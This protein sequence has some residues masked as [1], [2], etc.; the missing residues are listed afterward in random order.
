MKITVI[1][2]GSTYTPELVNG[3]LARVA[4]LPLTELCLMDIDEERLKIVGGFAQ[5]MVNAKGNPFKVTLT[6]DQREAVAGASYIITQLRVG[7][8]Q[9]RKGDEYLGQRHG[10]IG[11]ET[12]GVGGMAKA[13]RTIPV[14]QRIVDDMRELAPNA[15]LANFTNP[16]GLVTEMLTRYAPDIPAVGVC[17][18][19][20]TAKMTMLAEYEKMAGETVTEER[21]VLSTLGLNHLTWHSGFQVDGEE[22]WGEIFPA[23]LEELRQQ[24]APEWDIRT[25]ETLGIIPNYYLQYFYY[26]DKKLKAQA[27]WPPSRAEEVMAIEKDLLAQYADPALSAPPEDLMKRGGAYYSTLAT[28]LIASHHND[29]GQVHIVNLR[30]NG[31]VPEYPAD[32]VLEM[33]AK[34]DKSGIHPLPAKAL[35]LACF[36]IVNAVKMY[37]L[38]TVEAALHADRN[39]AYQALLAHPLGPSA[40][41]IQAVLDDML[42]TNRQWLP[43]FE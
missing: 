17:N 32:W 14:I 3:F 13:L 9:A 20:I 19:G 2:G 6:L 8:M 25:L 12:T 24:D 23:Y 33:P 4:S 27:A 41:K 7:M 29:L 35:P 37:E 40:D 38:L 10:L 15:L 30:N 39:A 1:G 34:V 43:Q 21:A 5:R 28:Q 22:K 16:A 18:V 26:T 42:E 11:Q 36:S 31:A